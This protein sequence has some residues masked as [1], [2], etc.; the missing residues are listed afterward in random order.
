MTLTTELFYPNWLTFRYYGSEVTDVLRMT[1]L[2]TTTVTAVFGVGAVLW[3]GRRKLKRRNN[4]GK[5]KRSIAGAPLES[6]PYPQPPSDGPTFQEYLSSLIG[7]TLVDRQQEWVATYGPIFMIPS[8]LKGFI[9]NF[10]FIADPIVTKELTITRTNQNRPPFQFQTRSELFAKA[11][12]DS[13]GHSLAGSTGDEW[14]WRRKAF[15][16]EM[17]KSKL[18]NSKRKLLEEIFHIGETK[19][20]QQL[21]QAAVSQEPIQVDIVATEAAMD[22]ILFF[23]FGTVLKGYDADQ[24]RQAAKDTLAY[25]MASLIDPL[26][27][28]KRYIPGTSACRA[29]QK[30][31]VAWDVFDSLVKEEVCIMIDE[32][33]G[34]VEKKNDR[35]PGSILESWLKNEPKF[36]E[37]SLDP[38]LAEVRGM[39]LA[40]FETTAHALAYSMGMM[41]ERP[42]LSERL[43]EVSNQALQACGNNGLSQL[44]EDTKYVKNF[45]M[46]ALRLYPL[47]FTLGGECTEDVVIS[48]GD[49]K[50]HTLPKGTNCLFMNFAMQ[51][52]SDY[53]DH[54]NDVDPDRWGNGKRQPFLHTFN[55]GP[56][57]CP[58]KPLSL[59]EGQIF[60]TQIASKFKFEFPPGIDRVMYDEQMLLRPKDGMPLMVTKRA[61]E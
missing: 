11:T 49:K 57:T 42:D 18:F 59:L 36:Y 38:I 48:V 43:Y 56:H 28:M 50:C 22:T 3:I 55:N 8:P 2:V 7:G 23:L 35:H 60:L 1:I 17:H 19:L 34:I 15:L 39:I 29:L 6:S 47:A 32:A 4:S 40:G 41:A 46:E 16:M 14:K 31:N 54:P 26:F 10:C 27:S 52:N 12:R 24:V 5:E 30:R 25:M 44:L 45:F 58:G 9:P 37:R 53:L 21:E 51:R 33:K 61:H 20:C 13:V